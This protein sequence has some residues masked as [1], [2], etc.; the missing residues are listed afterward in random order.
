MFFK[1]TDPLRAFPY[2]VWLDCVRH[3]SREQAAGPLPLLAVSAAWRDRVLDAPEVWT[4]NHFDGGH[5]EECRAA[6][7]FHLSQNRSV[8]IIVEQN[9]GSLKIA[10]QYTHR[11]RSTFFWISDEP[12]TS[13]FYESFPME[14][15]GR[16]WYSC[17]LPLILPHQQNSHP[18]MTFESQRSYSDIEELLTLQ[19]RKDNDASVVPVA[20]GLAAIYYHQMRYSEAI[21]L[22]KHAL[23]YY[24]TLSCGN[25]VATILVRFNLAIVL[26][27]Q[28]LWGQI[29]PLFLDIT[30]K[31][32]D[33]I[34]Q[35]KVMGLELLQ[36]GIV[37]TRAA[38]LGRYHHRTIEDLE[39]LS[40]IYTLQDLHD[41]AEDLQQELQE[42]GRQQFSVILGP[43]FSP[44][45]RIK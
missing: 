28:S 30:T 27:K 31:M 24:N 26:A 12:M 36:L 20:M 4:T 29:E 43:N 33:L 8:D 15:F 5:D 6:S 32:R 14:R 45:R 1:Q 2:E 16:K 44:R 9:H 19:S 13:I 11:I 10:M 7:F 40:S 38:Y 21:T 3:Y 23:E 42:E 39:A 37:E 34:S 35:R 18:L 25:S 17:L 41:A 22:A